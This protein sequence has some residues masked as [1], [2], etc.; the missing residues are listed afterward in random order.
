[1]ETDRIVLIVVRNNKVIEIKDL[2]LTN[3][4]N[5][6]FLGSPYNDGQ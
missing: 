1:M 6:D 5:L 2:W 3:R 4:P